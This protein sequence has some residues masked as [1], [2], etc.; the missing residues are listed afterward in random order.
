MGVGQ[1]QKL[2]ELGTAVALPHQA[3]NLAAPEIDARQQAPGAMADVFMIAPQAGV[4]A[5]DG[6][7]VGGRVLDRLHPRLLI[8]RQHR[9]QLRGSAQLV[10]D[11]DLLVDVQD[12]MMDYPAPHK[13]TLRP[14]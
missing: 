5:R 14:I 4:L 13:N 6:R 12:L 10:P 9:D 3:Q 11:L 2:D 7:Q 8:V 1:A